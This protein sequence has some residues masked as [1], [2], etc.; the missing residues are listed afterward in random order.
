MI[1]DNCDLK[2]HWILISPMISYIKSMCWIWK[3]SII[4]KKNWLLGFSTSLKQ[5]WFPWNT[6]FSY[7]HTLLRE[8]VGLQM[9]HDVHLDFLGKKSETFIT[10]ITVKWYT[11]KHS[12]ILHFLEFSP[13]PL[14]EVTTS[15]K[16]CCC[17]VSGVSG[18]ALSPWY[19]K[20][21][22]ATAWCAA[23]GVSVKVSK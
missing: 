15:S 14:P 11:T 2:L 17:S 13:F 10:W 19:L 7:L 1:N 12:E 22:A 20:L 5:H 8:V 18:V 3:P 4:N 21:F 16:I 23:V 6:S 9:L